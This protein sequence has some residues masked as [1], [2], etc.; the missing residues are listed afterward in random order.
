M[1]IRKTHSKETKFKAALALYK[2]DKTIAEISQEYGVCQSVLHRWKKTLLETGSELFDDRRGKKV[3][4]DHSPVLER[5][6]G[7]LT[8]EIDFLKKVLGQ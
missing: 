8:M 5:K 1:S 2:S 6:I 3:T 4:N 7:Q